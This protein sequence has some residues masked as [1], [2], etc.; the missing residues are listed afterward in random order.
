MRSK[1][2]RARPANRIRRILPWPPAMWRIPPRAKCEQNSVY[3]LRFRSEYVRRVVEGCFV[4]R[5]VLRVSNKKRATAPIS[6]PLITSYAVRLLALLRFA[7][8]TELGSAFNLRTAFRAELLLLDGLAAL[9]QEHCRGFP[10]PRHDLFLLAQCPG[11]AGLY[12]CIGGFVKL[13]YN[14]DTNSLTRPT[15]L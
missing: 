10:R 1:V 3:P 5:Y 6:H 13:R 4:T 7:L 12:H 15:R 11:N 8:R 9:D 2:W 14:C